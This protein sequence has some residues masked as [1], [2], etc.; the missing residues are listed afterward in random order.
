MTSAKE[1]RYTDPKLLA[2]ARR[3]LLAISAVLDACGV[4]Y[5]LEGGTLLGIARDGDLL[6]WDN[7]MDLSIPAEDYPR[8]AEK[9]LPRLFLKG[10]RT[11]KRRFPSDQPMWRR[12]AVRMIKVRTRRLLVL[13]GSPCLDV[14]VK[15]RHDGHVYWQAGEKIMRVPAD[16]YDADSSL[17]WQGRALRVPKA[18]E[19]YLELKYGNWRTPVKHW[20]CA[21]DEKTIVGDA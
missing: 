8:F 17:Q 21:T 16:I 20:N 6:P 15:F 18:Y 7:D 2:R 9:A 19:R 13:R 1:K 3:M 14:F 10:L 4:R 12:G 5:H 11:S